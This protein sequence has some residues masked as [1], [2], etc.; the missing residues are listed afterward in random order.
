MKRGRRRLL[1]TVKDH[2]PEP[3]VERSEVILF[4]YRI[5]QSPQQA[6]GITCSIRWNF[7]AAELT[8]GSGSSGNQVI[9]RRRPE[10]N[11]NVNGF[12]RER[13]SCRL[14]PHFQHSENCPSISSPQ[15]SH[16]QGGL[17]EANG[18]RVLRRIL[19]A[20]PSI[21][22]STT[23]ISGQHSMGGSSPAAMVRSYFLVTHSIPK[24]ARTFLR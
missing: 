11:T 17:T 2:M 13:F 23:H 15:P 24:M 4:A 7:S 14:C 3:G 20:R 8:F 10:S 18:A 21:S 12:R 9:Y 6:C 16:A 22:S 5:A 1:V 19:L